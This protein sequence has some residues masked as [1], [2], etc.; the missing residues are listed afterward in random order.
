[1]LSF[2]REVGLPHSRK[3]VYNE[4]ELINFINL[5]NGKSNVYTTV[6]GYK[7]IDKFR[8]K[9]STATVDRIFFDLDSDKS[10][11][12][13]V[14]LHNHFLKNNFKHIVNFSGGGFHLFLFALP[15]FLLNP[16]VALYN[17]QTTIAKEAGLSIGGDSKKFDLDGHIIGDLAR[18]RRVENTFNLKRDKFCIT[19]TQEDLDKG[20]EWIYE[21]AKHQTNER[22]V[23][24]EKLFDLRPFDTTERLFD[25]S[26]IEGMEVNKNDFDLKKIEKYDFP[27]CVLAL[28][29]KGDLDYL[30]R[31]QLITYL[32]TYGLTQSEVLEILKQFLLPANPARFKKGIL[33]ERQIPKVFE[34]GGFYDFSQRQMKEWR[35][36]NLE[37]KNKHALC[38]AK[39]NEKL[40]FMTNGGQ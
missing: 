16:S 14:K 39:L 18:L 40:K 20:I 26:V 13:T 38:S 15:T 6:Y 3:V 12:N 9:Y 27:D 23:W 19:L 25:A 17:A 10:F 24:G 8:C 1:M 29:K 5:Y 22:Q 28:L 30:E 33:Q 36:C 7:E 32:K 31:F 35:I 34:K 4:D 37:C 2:P 21:K 11:E